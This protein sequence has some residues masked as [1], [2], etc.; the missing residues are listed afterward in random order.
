[1]YAPFQ[2]HIPES[3]LRIPDLQ[4]L[5]VQ[6]TLPQDSNAGLRGRWHN[7]PLDIAGTIVDTPYQS[8]P[9]CW[10]RVEDLRNLLEA[11]R[12]KFPD[13]YWRTRCI[14]HLVLFEV[15]D[16]I[17]AGC[18][19]VWEILCLGIEE[20]LLKDDWYCKSGLK[21]RGRIFKYLRGI[22]E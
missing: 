13:T 18:I 3:P 6:V 7:D 14:T 20:L 16:L 12:L 9:F 17:K 15:D 4:G 1:M 21:T 5:L 8:H 22:K 19:V 2:L 11:F 10:E